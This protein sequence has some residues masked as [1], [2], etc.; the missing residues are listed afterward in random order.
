MMQPGV[1]PGPEPWYPIST[2]RWARLPVRI[3][4]PGYECLAVVREHPGAKRLWWLSLDVA[5][6]P[7]APIAPYAAPGDR[8]APLLW[9]PPN[10]AIWPHPLPA[11]VQEPPR[12]PGQHS[13]PSEPEPDDATQAGD[14]W[15]YPWLRLGQRV[16][17]VSIEE[18]EARLLRALRTSAS[19]ETGSVGLA[20]RSTCADIPSEYVKIALE[21]ERALA[22]NRG[23][24]KPDMHA[25]RSGWT[26]V[27]RDI[28]D[29]SY[30]LGW[31]AVLAWDDPMRDVLEMRA[32]DP[33]FSFR[34]IAE[35][36]PGRRRARAS[37]QAIHAGYVAAV[38]RVFD[39][40]I[41][42]GIET[43]RMGDGR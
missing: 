38:S 33:P 9:Q 12:D 16:P 31:L 36:M 37:A 39:A 25:V 18:C 40:A 32:A 8:A 29:W 7:V 10:A 17:P 13:A 15:P 42:D 3:Q 27:R 4:G 22:I 43:G 23:D 28:E 41:N 19:R 34:A 24:Y 26:P 5:L 20:H 6:R 11:P 30:A 14:G 21:Y 2:M 35:L 1:S